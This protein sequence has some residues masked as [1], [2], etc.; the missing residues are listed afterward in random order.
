[1]MVDKT[2]NIFVAACTP[3]GNTMMPN[4]MQRR[5]APKRALAS[6]GGI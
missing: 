2:L 6:A 5:W 4:L 3:I 1:M